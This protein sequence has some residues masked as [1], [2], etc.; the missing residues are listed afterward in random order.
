MLAFVPRG[1]LKFSLIDAIIPLHGLDAKDVTIA[2][3][4]PF[5]D[6][7]FACVV[8][9][10]SSLSSDENQRSLSSLLECMASGSTLYVHDDKLTDPARQEALLKDML[11]SGF[12]NGQLKST[13]AGVVLKASKPNWEVGAKTL[14]S[15]KNKPAP[16]PAPAP[17]SER[18]TWTVAGDE[19]ELMDE[20][21]LLT[22]ADKMP[23]LPPP[24]IS[25][26]GT[27]STK[28]ACKNCS[29]G[30]AEMEAA[31][32]KGGVAVK[33]STQDVVDG[34]VDLPTSA[35]GSCYLGDAFRC[36]SC[37]YKGLPAF[38]KDGSK[39]KLKL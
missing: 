27:G 35:C 6:T 16:T 37:P 26:C 2:S 21:D 32:E 4:G 3:N 36:A 13:A 11:L 23:P 30:R 38:E 28:K 34:A 29:C 15:R 18:K 1:T 31:E 20:D 39:V 19:E 33:I 17:E 22:E 9:S 24:S 8:A 7:S 12:S 14:L 5:P 10:S 25:D